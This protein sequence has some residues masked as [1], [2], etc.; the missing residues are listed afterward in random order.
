MPTPS[1]TAK[2]PLSLGQQTMLLLG[3]FLLLA[4]LATGAAFYHVQRQDLLAHQRDD[5]EALLDRAA[6]VIRDSVEGLGGDTL[7]LA[8]VRSA[9]MVADGAC[10]TKEPGPNEPC[11]ALEN[12]AA[13]FDALL[14]THPEY[15]QVRLIGQAEGGRELL[16]LDRRDGQV[17]RIPATELQAKG[18]RPYVRDTLALPKGALY[19]SRVDL[20]QEH[21]RIE[22]PH[23]PVLRMATPLY[24]DQGTLFGILVVNLA[25]GP[26]LDRLATLAPRGTRLYVTNQEG[27]LLLAPERDLTFGFDLGERHLI[28]DQHPE[29][30]P[31]FEGRGEPI[32]LGHEHLIGAR[33]VELHPHWPDRTLSV[34]AVQPMG[35]LIGSLR[36]SLWFSMAISAALLLLG[37]LLALLT[38]RGLSRDLR[39]L[40][41]VARRFAKGDITPAVP[42][43]GSREIRELGEAFN[44]MR[45]EVIQRNIELRD[46]EAYLRTIIE[47]STEGIIT[48]DERGIMLT[49]NPSA[50][51]MFGYPPEEM[52]GQNVSMLMPSTYASEHDRY[53]ADFTARHGDRPLIGRTVMGVRKNGSSFPIGIGLASFEL[54]GRHRFAAFIQDI[55]ELQAAED[56]IRQAR[57][58]ESLAYYD[59]LTNLP[60]RRLLRE[61]LGRQLTQAA[62][63]KQRLAVALIDLDGFKEVNDR[64]GHE[65]GDQLLKV[66][67]TRLTANLRGSDIVSRMGGDEFA[68][69]L[70]GVHS[71]A[72]K[73]DDLQRPMGALIRS[74]AEPIAIGN[75]FVRVSASIGISLFP[76][77]GADIDTLLRQA[78][79]AMYQ[80]KSLGRNRYLFF[81][82]AMEENL[83]QRH[84]LLTQL[85]AAIEQDELELHY[86]PQVDMVSGEVTG[87]EALVRWNSP[88]HGLRMPGEFIPLAEESGLIVR[89]G[90]W[91]LRAALRQLAEWNQH[92]LRLKLGI[93]VAAR[94]FLDPHFVEELGALLRQHGNVHPGQIVLEITETA[95]M[96]D[97]QR[98]REI[99]LA[100]Q[101][102]GIGFSLDDFG[103]GFSSLIYLQQLPV[104]SLKIDR[105]FVRNILEHAND[106]AIAKG[107]IDMAH[108]LDLPVIAEGV[109]DAPLAN[110]LLEFGCRCGQG[111]GIARPMPAGALPDW[112]RTW[113]RPSAW[114][115]D[116][117]A[118]TTDRHFGL[119]FAR[120]AHE[121]W[122]EQL[123]GWVESAPGTRLPQSVALDPRQ[124]S[125]GRWY[126]G[127][128]QARYGR[129]PAFVRLHDVHHD[130]HRT[131]SAMLEHMQAHRQDDARQLIPELLS[132][133]DAL[134]DLLDELRRQ[135][136]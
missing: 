97:L 66:I 20:N 21:G 110:R 116:I 12:L 42:H 70:S 29:L 41:R 93:N 36:A 67:A 89:L 96:A 106:A 99:I 85:E 126:G 11:A 24:S 2:R 133:R 39:Q 108:L 80:A 90:H 113:R 88:S 56:A 130:V 33:R 4:S 82:K 15:I 122:L 87:A 127:P 38:T 95:A 55:T 37:M 134:F 123:L 25:Y 72:H 86:Q 23:T 32:L 124:C 131:A 125:F 48:T 71:H 14:R 128:G 51:R 102:M 1:R 84:E 121:N 53:I 68:L 31:W 13:I 10:Q 75:D 120:Q 112:I 18:D 49:V 57:E 65:A 94:Q 109:E 135:D 7:L 69:V 5:L 47:T 100:C 63:H 28:Q 104:Q 105:S 40:A 6:D 59:P 79:I 45:A 52:L 54:K 19:L 101:T 17:V 9:R 91:I 30:A 46:Q 62:A 111:Y 83:L 58:I 64:M 16:R 117:P 3:G 98:A 81:D 136:D 44:A 22:V 8:E 77:D 118:T 27:D 73:E 92:G 50:A 78:D 26:V 114:R 74:V 107:I 119:L 34:F 61:R 60:N 132:H 35:T 103:T 115:T 76:D 129:H 43:S